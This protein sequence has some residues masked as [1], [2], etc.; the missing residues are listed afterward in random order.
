MEGG[1]REV[2]FVTGG[3]WRLIEGYRLQATDCRLIGRLGDGRSQ[4]GD[5]GFVN[6]KV[7]V[8]ESGVTD[9]DQV[10]GVPTGV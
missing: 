1:R 8:N 9:P 10:G 2:E 5:W 3:W 6:V 7:N 4:M